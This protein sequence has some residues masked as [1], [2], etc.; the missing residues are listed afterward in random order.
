MKRFILALIT[1]TLSGSTAFSQTETVG[2][3]NNSAESGVDFVLY[4]PEV[5]TSSYLINNCGELV[6]QWTFSDK[7]GITCYLL[8]NGNILQNG[9]PHLELRDW[10]NNLIWSFDVST[11]GYNKHHDIEPL[12]NGNILLLIN[13]EYTPDQVIALGKDPSTLGTNFKI[14][15]IIELEPTG[16]D[17]ANVVWEWKFVDHLIQDFDSGK[18]NFGVVA[19][20]PELLDFNH[21]QSHATD[22]T[23]AY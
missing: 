14:D 7:P 20:H 9:R 8:E 2:L 3:T 12:P 19:D 22:F 23:H 5:S 17:G 4:N 10:D 21:A 6:N 11:L 18:P 13:D 15:K 1:F 16:I